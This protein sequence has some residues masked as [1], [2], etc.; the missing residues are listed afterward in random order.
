MTWQMSDNPSRVT[1]DIVLCAKLLA[2]LRPPHDP[3]TEEQA[4]RHIEP[5][6]LYDLAEGILDKILGESP[7]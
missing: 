1:E 6:A 7:S 2:V 5:T 3:N 4:E